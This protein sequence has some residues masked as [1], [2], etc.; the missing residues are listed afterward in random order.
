MSKLDR[1]DGGLLTLGIVGAL[2]AA[3]SIRRGSASTRD[4][5]KTKR[6]LV[7]ELV[8][9]IQSRHPEVSA[10][11]IRE[12]ARQF[13]KRALIEALETLRSDDLVVIPPMASWRGQV[14]SAN[15]DWQDDWKAIQQAYKQEEEEG[16]AERGWEE[17]Q[18]QA[19]SKRLGPDIGLGADWSVSAWHIGPGDYLTDERL[20]GLVNAYHMASSRGDHATWDELRT[21][22]HGQGIDPQKYS[23]YGT[24][25]EGG[26]IYLLDYENG[27]YGVVQ[28]YYVDDDYAGISDQNR[29][30]YA[31]GHNDAIVDIASFDAYP[32]FPEVMRWL[33]ANMPKLQKGK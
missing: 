14:G 32:P 6:V 23:R 13:T 20:V 19:I 11:A 33:D 10:R 21:R 5:A 3:G 17:L 27:S 25:I 12:K 28:R 30:D 22:L 2:A 24:N 18:E 7:N 29:R 26:Q 9:Q 4:H 31:D 8:Q 16:W 15:Y 1:T